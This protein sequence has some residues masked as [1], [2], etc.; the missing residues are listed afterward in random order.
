MTNNTLKNIAN[1]AIYQVIKMITANELKIPQ[2]LA[3]AGSK[4]LPSITAPASAKRQI[5]GFAF[6]ID[7]Y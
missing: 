1:R 6:S 5:G 3:V 4:P 2:N 7:Q